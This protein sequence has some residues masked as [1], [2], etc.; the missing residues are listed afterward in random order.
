MKRNK[1]IDEFIEKAPAAS[2][3]GLI[4]IREL[5]HQLVPE[6]EET[7]TY[8]IPTYKLNGNLVHFSGYEKHIGFYPGPT[9]IIEFS[10]DLKNYVSSK[11]SVQFPVDQMLPL[12]LIERIVKFRLAENLN[13]SMSK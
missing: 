7:I 12:K 11:G 6:A 4:Q 5:I 2:R 10:E 3:Q 1:S 13:K 9:G 8:G